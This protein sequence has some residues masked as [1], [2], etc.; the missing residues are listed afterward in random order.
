MI[1]KEIYDV[2]IPLK[3]KTI[4]KIK[5][6]L[7]QA[8]EDLNILKAQIPEINIYSTFHCTFST[9]LGH[10]LQEVAAVCGNHVVN[11]DKQEKKTVGIDIR[12]EFGEGQMKLT[13]TTQTGT[14]KQD[15]IDKLLETTKKN[16]TNPF[17]VTAL[18]ESYHYYKDG[19]F[20]VGGEYFWSRIGINYDDLCDTIK[21]V[22]KETYE[23]V[24]ST[25]IPTIRRT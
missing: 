20:Y 25:I 22:I 12:T 21:Q 24:E 15:S 3:D 19:I 1:S 4:N 13:K 11:I 18:S 14:H 9:C 23:E 5:Y 7:N 10:K 8:P 2:L 17:F 6:N 16:N